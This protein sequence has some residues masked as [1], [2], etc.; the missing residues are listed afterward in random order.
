MPGQVTVDSSFS[1]VLSRI[2]IRR[3]PGWQLTLLLKPK[4]P[5]AARQGPLG[6]FFASGFPDDVGTLVLP[7][8]ASPYIVSYHGNG[9]R[10]RRLQGSTRVDPPQAGVRQKLARRKEGEPPGEFSPRGR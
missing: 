2:L 5:R 7:G 10:P 8:R 9:V 4:P 3:L 6:G 1:S